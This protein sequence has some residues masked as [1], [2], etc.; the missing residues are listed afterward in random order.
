MTLIPKEKCWRHKNRE[1]RGQSSDLTKY[2]QFS[3]LSEPELPLL[4]GGPQ[5]IGNDD[6]ALI[7]TEKN[8]SDA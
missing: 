5:F 1:A 8:D 6:P 3:A 2:N 4:K 7:S